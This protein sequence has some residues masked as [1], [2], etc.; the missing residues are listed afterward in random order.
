M[1]VVQA[2]SPD[3]PALDLVAAALRR[4]FSAGAVTTAPSNSAIMAVYVNPAASQA[5][6]VA[7]ILGHGGKVALFGRIPAN[8]AVLAG[9]R[10]VGDPGANWQAAA[11]A[12]PAPARD[13]SASAAQV[14]WSHDGLA[15]ES[16]FAARPFLRYD[17]AAE[18]NN[19][20]FGAITADGGPWALA[21]VVQAD[22]AQVLAHATA[23]DMITPFVTL[24]DLETGS[25]LWWNRAVAGMDS[26]EWAVLEAFFCDWRHDVLPCQAVIEEI[27]HGYDAAITM[28]LDC[29]EDIASARPVFDL[30]HGRSLP[31]SL[32]VMTGQA[33]A[34]SP[35]NIA[36]LADVVANGGA[37]LVH[38]ITHLPNWGGSAETC[39]HEAVVARAFLEKHLPGTV[40]RHAVSPFHQNPPYVPDA[41]A[42]AGLEGFVGGIIANDPE[43]LVARGG[44]LASSHLGVITHSQQ[45]MLHG[46]CLLAEG[47]AMAVPKQAFDAARASR[48][49][50]AISIIRSP[51]ATTMAGDPSS[52][53]SMPMSTSSTISAPAVGASS[54]STRTTRWTGSPPRVA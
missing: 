24:R 1:I 35:A 16:P 6:D 50:S 49:S 51:G 52:A 17:F 44:L 10:L 36:L 13:V 27:P 14:I 43:A 15:A 42:G 47:D 19:L 33:D 39:A 18:W 54:G 31:F 8:V 30:Y 32:A 45:C 23:P 3:D 26:Y 34:D 25:L 4:S 21:A 41:L 46:D 48:T 2:G 20:G 22:G 9:L 37:V 29:D 12:P 38:S 5:D 53:G 28:R 11:G 7:Q 40:V